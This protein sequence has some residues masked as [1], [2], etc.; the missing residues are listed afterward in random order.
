VKPDT[1]CWGIY[2]LNGLLMMARNRS[3]TDRTGIVLIRSLGKEDLE[4]PLS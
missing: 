4:S 3:A 1:L 2:W